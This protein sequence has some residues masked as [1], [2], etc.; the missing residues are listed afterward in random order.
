MIRDDQSLK[1][2]DKG[3]MSSSGLFLLTV[4]ML[5]PRSLE[6]SINNQLHAKPVPVRSDFTRFKRVKRE[7]VSLID[8][9]PRM[10]E[11]MYEASKQYSICVTAGKSA[12]VN[13]SVRFEV[14]F[15]VLI[16]LRSD[17]HSVLINNTLCATR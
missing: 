10:T 2:F 15:V 8:S 4:E 11:L 1:S 9:Y 3:T 17:S 16:E 7:R 13:H 6:A 5:H 12:A 14:L